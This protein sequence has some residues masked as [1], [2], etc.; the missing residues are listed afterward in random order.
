[1]SKPLVIDLVVGCRPNFVKAAAIIHAAEKYPNTKINLIHTGQHSSDLSDPFF[2]E[3]ELPI[4]PPSRRFICSH[5]DNAVS[6][7]SCLIGWMGDVFAEDK[8]DL[9]MVVGDTDSTLAGA[10][11]AAKLN[12]CL[13][14]V[15]AGLR[16]GDYMM[17]EELNR[18]M[19]DSVSDICYTTTN[20]ARETLL[21]EGHNP[22]LVKFV[23]NV[24]VDTLYRFLPDAEKKYPHGWSSP[25]AVLTLHRAETVDHDDIVFPAL[26]AVRKV[27][28]SID[29]VW[30]VH[31]RI[32]SRLGAWKCEGQFT[33]CEPM[34][35]LQFISLLSSAKFVMTDSGGVQ[36]ET[37]ALGIPCL[38][39][40]PSTERP[41]TV[42][43]GTNRVIGTN[44]EVIYEAAAALAVCNRSNH[45][46]I[47]KPP[48]WDG[49]AA[50]R[51]LA[52]LAQL[53]EK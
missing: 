4:P 25:Y 29:V 22:A 21:A 46:Y 26:D 6:R 15:E 49:R 19:V 30:P 16:C 36:E 48:L 5:F 35:Y 37:T 40:R 12:I 14:H 13:V 52:D 27:A 32:R 3:L 31:P 50:D 44:P 51:I 38:T 41:E 39:L 42:S 24:M 20:A 9:V 2:D 53:G 43:M 10:V 1:M 18:K 33:R 7:L 8:P 45:T 28:E 11:A 34:G 23:G 17:Q 47:D